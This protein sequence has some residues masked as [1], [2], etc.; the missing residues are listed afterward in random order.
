MSEETQEDW[1]ETSCYQEG[2]IQDEMETT[3]ELILRIKR[4]K[5]ERLREYSERTHEICQRINSNDELLT[6]IDF[7]SDINPFTSLFFSNY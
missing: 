5:E 7:S 4:I 6:S 2:G 3:E 1:G